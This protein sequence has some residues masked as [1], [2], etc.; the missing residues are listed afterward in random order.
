MSSYPYSECKVMLDFPNL[1]RS[2]CQ[3]KNGKVMYVEENGI[4]KLIVQHGAQTK[5]F[6]LDAKDLLHFNLSTMNI[7]RGL[8]SIQLTYSFGSICNIMISEPLTM[9]GLYT[10]VEALTIFIH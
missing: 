4:P 6:D 2:N 10:L 8:V 7:E 9:D 5:H 3:K 1:P